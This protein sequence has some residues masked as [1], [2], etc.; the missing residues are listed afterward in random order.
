MECNT[1]SVGATLRSEDTTM[2]FCLSQH[3]ICEHY[4]LWL[5]SEWNKY[6]R[7]VPMEWPVFLPNI[8]LHPLPGLLILSESL[9]NN[10]VQIPPLVYS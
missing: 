8:W 1:Y 9:H 6:T 10:M 5:E 2:T 4:N 3:F 7:N